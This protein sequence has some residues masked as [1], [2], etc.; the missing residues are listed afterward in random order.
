MLVVAVELL[1]LIFETGLEANEEHSVQGGGRARQA[2]VYPE[3]LLPANY[4][5]MTP[6]VR[7]VPRNR[8]LR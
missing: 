4:N 5:P 1:H 3:P 7:E 8:G 2:V 6:E